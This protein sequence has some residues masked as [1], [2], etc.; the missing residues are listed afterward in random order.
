MSSSHTNL[1]GKSSAFEYWPISVC[2]ALAGWVSQSR[3]LAI[4]PWQQLTQGSNHLKAVNNEK[5]YSLDYEEEWRKIRHLSFLLHLI[6]KEREQTT[7]SKK[8]MVVEY[9][10]E[11]V[12][13]ENV[14]KIFRD[15]GTR[16]VNQ[17]FFI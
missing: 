11:I 1:P 14:R 2:I 15:R 7:M 9:T 12:Q 16:V 3:R 5:E 4:R 6:L 13:L 8:R 17:P 10:Q